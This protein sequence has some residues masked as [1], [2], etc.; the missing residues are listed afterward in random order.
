[1]S[2]ILT[3]LVVVIHNVSSVHRVTEFAKLIAGLGLKYVIYTKV[4]GAAAQQGIPEAFK[5][6]AKQGSTILVLPD[7]TDVYELI[8]PERTYFL[9]TET[10]HERQAVRLV[11]I[12]DE[13]LSLTGQ[14]KKIVLVVNG[15]DLP[16][17]PRETQGGIL[18]KVLNARLPSTAVLALALYE[19]IRK[20]PSTAHTLI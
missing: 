8:R 10:T 20:S 15:S 6:A 17:T 1:M 5:I 19:I 3:N 9:V 18:V 4:T 7:I 2:N 12:I 14:G 11:D 13:I 16:F